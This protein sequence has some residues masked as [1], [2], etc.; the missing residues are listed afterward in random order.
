MGEVSQSVFVTENFSEFR[1]RG[2]DLTQVA[3]NKAAQEGLTLDDSAAIQHF[4]KVMAAQ[5]QAWIPGSQ[6]EVQVQTKIA[7]LQAELP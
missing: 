5:L 2:I 7:A 1:S 3:H 6:H 4:A